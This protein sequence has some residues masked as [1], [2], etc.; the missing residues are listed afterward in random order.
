MLLSEGVQLGIPVLQRSLVLL[1]QAV[2][3]LAVRA[4]QPLHLLL[5][6]QLCLGML[7]DI[8]SHCTTLHSTHNRIKVN[9][10]IVTCL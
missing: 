10:D 8:T 7:L 1:F 6:R 2:Q 9:S 5:V 4:L 3:A